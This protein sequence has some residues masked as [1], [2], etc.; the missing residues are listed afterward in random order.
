MLQ[1]P[2]HTGPNLVSE[3]WK[4]HDGKEGS[5]DF[6]KLLSWDDTDEG[7]TVLIRYLMY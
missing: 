6:S 2:L 4:R 1:E 5:E 3:E 7:T